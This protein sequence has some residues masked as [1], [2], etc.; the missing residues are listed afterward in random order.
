MLTEEQQRIVYALDKH[1]LVAAGAGS[2]KTRVLV[3]RYVQTLLHNIDKLTPSNIVAVTYTKRAAS[4]MRNR[5]KGR[6]D[7]LI[8]EA[9]NLHIKERLYSF[10]LQ[11]DSVLIGTIHS[12]CDSILRTFPEEA[13]VDPAFEV[14]DTLDSLELIRES[15]EQALL[16]LSDSNK[17][18]QQLLSQYDIG[19]VIGWIKKAI[20]RRAEFTNA[21]KNLPG[22]S[23]KDMR[24]YATKLLSSVQELCCAKAFKNNQINSY[25]DYVA[26]F[27]HKEVRNEKLGVALAT[28]LAVHKRLQGATSVAEKFAC[29]KELSQLKFSGGRRSGEEA[30]LES[31]VKEL[32]A[33]ACGLVE[34]IPEQLN[35]LDEES[36]A[37]IPALITSYERALEI[38]KEKKQKLKALDYHDQIE[39][40]CE[41]LKDPHSRARQHFNGHLAAVLV[42]EFQD[43]NSLQSEIIGYLAGPR[44]RVLLI[45]DEKQSIYKFQGADLSVFASWTST[46]SSKDKEF[47]FNWE[48]DRI[49]E[50]L[51]LSFRAH[52]TL[53]SFI[54]NVFHQVLNGHG[55]M[56]KYHAQYRELVAAREGEI[57]ARTHLVHYMPDQ[58]GA[59]GTISDEGEA[60][61]TWIAEMVETKRPVADESGSSRPAQYGDF[62][63]LLPQH[64]SFQQFEEAFTLFSLPYASMGGK[65]FLSTQEVFDMEN[66]LAFV[67]APLNDQALFGILRSPFFGLSDDVLQLLFNHKQQS[68]QASLWRALLSFTEQGDLQDERLNRAVAILKALLNM[69][70][71]ASLSQ[72]L[73][74]AIELTS[75]DITILSLP[76]GKRRSRNVWK[77][78]S[79]AEE[80]ESLTVLQFLQRL[81]TARIAGA[82]ERAAPLDAG[83]SIKLMTIHQAKGLE[84]PIVV[85]PCMDT[86]VNPSFGGSDAKL[87]FHPEYGIAFNTGQGKEKSAYFQVCKHIQDEL[88]AAEKRRLF[89]VAASRAKDHL[90]IFL[91]DK[92]IEQ[93]CF[94]RWLREALTSH[95]VPLPDTPPQ[96]QELRGAFGVAP[97]IARFHTNA[98]ETKISAVALV[99]DISTGET[100]R[101][102]LLLSKVSASINKN[103]LEPIP[104]PDGAVPEPPDSWLRVTSHSPDYINH[105]LI[106]GTYFH[107]V[108]EYFAATKTKPDTKTLETLAR[109]LNGRATDVD[110]QAALVRQVEKLLPIFYDSELYSMMMNAQKLLFERAY[111]PF[112]DEGGSSSKRPDL[113]LQDTD[114]NWRIVDYKTDAVKPDTLKQEISRHR[115][116]IL[117]YVNDIKTICNIDAPGYLYFAQS[118]GLQGVT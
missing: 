95:E 43:T 32:C 36:F 90:G 82:E 99:D 23:E 3:E 39:A 47:P 10:R 61:A 112:K 66:L 84:F 89:Y 94:Q 76:S 26:G 111:I 5:I 59:Q 1:V 34:N 60:V 27:E 102:D 92:L 80:Q 18:I 73:R 53:T 22:L 35:S 20:G 81:E 42:D 46:F 48:G 8:A 96:Q 62:A 44:A 40:A 71:R 107:N 31:Q 45:G 103:L 24:S 115:Q 2:G 77:F 37:L 58:R 6:L 4:E 100:P 63:V 25:L 54:N 12:L 33:F 69:A 11:I 116:Q 21:C 9:G 101:G 118:G 57:E 93:D 17:Q 15:V 70:Q 85:L 50:T 83:N 28:V 49:L 79:M 30:E 98:E 52:P 117:T 91:Q 68:K 29:L 106:L 78:V 88:E 16:E 55:L 65:S 67:S 114:G 72:L 97:Y 13:K 56:S 110:L 104:H 14:L 64:S 41:L 105:E 74:K 109:S 38:Y 7:E 87:L 113:L 51:S 108:M 75:Y 19:N 86:P